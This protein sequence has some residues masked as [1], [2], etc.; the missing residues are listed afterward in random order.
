MLLNDK[1]LA[2]LKISYEAGKLGGSSGSD[3]ESISGVG[4]GVGLRTE[5]NKTT[6]LQTEIKQVNYNKVTSGGANYTSSATVG[7]AGVVFKF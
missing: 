5:I 1:T 4:Y 6:F 3:E 2:Y 7:S